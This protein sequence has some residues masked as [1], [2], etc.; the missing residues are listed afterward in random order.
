LD[1]TYDA[2]NKTLTISNYGSGISLADMKDIYY[3]DSSKPNNL[4]GLCTPQGLNLKIK[5][6]G[7]E[8]AV[9]PNLTL[10]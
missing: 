4:R 9:A 6:V 8:S 1:A 2:G 7:N 5:G 3:G 10:P